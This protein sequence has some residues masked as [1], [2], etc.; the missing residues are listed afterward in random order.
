MFQVIKKII[1]DTV[2]ISQ[3]YLLGPFSP[4]F[5]LERYIVNNLLSFLPD[6]AHELATNKLHISL[7]R[8][9]DMKNVVRCIY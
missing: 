9:S 2:D 1:M 6:D 5:N 3:Q 7:T 8:S 4:F